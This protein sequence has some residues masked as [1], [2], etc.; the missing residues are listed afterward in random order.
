MLKSL[1]AF[2]VK[3]AGTTYFAAFFTVTVRSNLAGSPLSAPAL[4]DTST[5]CMPSRLTCP[6]Y[7]RLLLAAESC[8]SVVMPIVGTA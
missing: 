1:Y 8:S 5:A 7:W 3:S 4:R 2:L 6:L